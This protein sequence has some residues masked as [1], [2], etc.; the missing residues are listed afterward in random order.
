MVSTNFFGVFLALTSA[1][2]Y[3]SAD[4]F[5]GVAT[6]KNN[7]YAVLSISSLVGVILMLVLALLKKE[8]FPDTESIIWAS[9]AGLT[10]AVGLG[11]LYYGLASG[12]PIIVS[13]VSGIAGA[14]LPIIFAFFTQKP[15]SS[16]QLI[17]FLTAL[18][19]IFFVSQSTQLNQDL[20]QTGK[21]KSK[22]INSIV[23]GISSGFFFGLFFICVAQ[24]KTQSFFMPLAISKSAS[25]LLSII[26]V[27]L[28][29]TKPP[30]VFKNPATILA[31]ILDPIANGLYLLSVQFT[32]L[33]TAAVL[34]S[35]YPAGTV[36]LTFIIQKKIIT[37]QQWLG[38]CLCLVA[39]VLITS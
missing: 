28:S 2:T 26:I 6:K 3:G 15:P 14:S 27:I 22:T 35:L 18:P 10:G 24:I 4:F 5:G 19:A 32:R 13:P 23:T 29:K 34:T 30:N 12:D 17:G 36:F 1:L 8:N 31:G 20:P 11:I 37:K 16:I 38:I 9:L 33:D 21:N 7:S 39:I 25:F